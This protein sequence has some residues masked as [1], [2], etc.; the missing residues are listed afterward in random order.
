MTNRKIIIFSVIIIFLLT[1]MNNYAQEGEYFINP[2]KIINGITIKRKADFSKYIYEYTIL[3]Q[4]DNPRIY[5]RGIINTSWVRER[6]ITSLDELNIIDKDTLIIPFTG[7][8]ADGFTNLPDGLYKIWLYETDKNN[9]SET[10]SYLYVVTVDTLSPIFNIQ[11][12]S[13]TIYIKNKQSLICRT[14]PV[15]EKANEWNVMIQKE[16]TIIKEQSFKAGENEIDFPGFSWIDYEYFD[17][18]DLALTIVVEAVDRAG[19]KETRKKDFVLTNREINN[20]SMQTI[21]KHETAN[22]EIN[23]INIP[24]IENRETI[25]TVYIPN[26][27]FVLRPEDYEIYNVKDGDYLAKIAREYYGSAP[28]WGIIYE[29]N[30]SRLPKEWDP[31]LILP[32]LELILPSKQLVSELIGAAKESKNQIE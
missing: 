20:I 12:I 8:E 26:G 25:I 31:N 3:D 2:D 4:L 10:N 13:D 21:E 19:N 28:L 15:S 23:D 29:I 7:R 24:K 14:I 9:T 18:E 11:L 6:F 22:N 1:V 17:Y 30:K 27:N 32:G 16:G 5:K